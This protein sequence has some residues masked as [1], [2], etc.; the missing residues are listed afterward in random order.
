VRRW[1]H[2]GEDPGYDEGRLVAVRSGVMHPS[3]MYGMRPGVFSSFLKRSKFSG[4]LTWKD[5][6][7]RK[8]PRSWEYREEHSGRIFT[9]HG[10]K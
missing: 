10:E 1:L 8:L 7:R 3:V 2:G 4:L 5:L 9:R 6:S